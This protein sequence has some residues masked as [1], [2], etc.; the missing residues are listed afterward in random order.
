MKH[1]TPLEPSRVIGEPGLEVFRFLCIVDGVNK[2]IHEPGERVLVHGLNVG[3][4][5][6]GEEQNGGV[7]CDRFVT[8]T[9]LVNLDLCCLCNCL[10]L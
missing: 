10:F 7:D 9:C 1:V 4:V 6:D 5:S 2:E 8:K 3:Q